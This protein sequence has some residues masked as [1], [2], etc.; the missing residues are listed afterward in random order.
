MS[1]D[2]PAGQPGCLF[3]RI[4]RGEIPATALYDDALVVA[5][6]DI[7]PMAPTHVLVIPKQHV[8]SL[9]HGTP[10]HEALFGRLM[11]VATDVARQEGITETGYRVVINTGADGGQ[12]V[13]HLHLHVLGGRKL[14][15]PPG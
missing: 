3:C 14:G 4:A 13:P 5:F 10:E 7:A 12:S 15:W 8:T 6:R 1:Q 11:R 9:A 2:A